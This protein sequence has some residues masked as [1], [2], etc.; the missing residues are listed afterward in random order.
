M[1]LDPPARL[2]AD[3]CER[4]LRTVAI[5]AEVAQYDAFEDAARL[6]QFADGVRGGVI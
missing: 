2:G 6:A 4:Q 5:A 1:N 3:G